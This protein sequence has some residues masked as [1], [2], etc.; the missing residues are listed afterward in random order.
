MRRAGWGSA[1]GKLDA[2]LLTMGALPHEGVV[3]I[4]GDRHWEE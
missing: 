1:D 3:R 2:Q 4:G